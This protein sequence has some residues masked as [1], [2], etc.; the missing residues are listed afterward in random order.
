MILS[1]RKVMLHIPEHGSL[2]VLLRGSTFISVYVLN[3][4]YVRFAMGW[5]LKHV[6]CMCAEDGVRGI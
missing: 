3:R 5:T 1:E 4:T 6:D 2:M